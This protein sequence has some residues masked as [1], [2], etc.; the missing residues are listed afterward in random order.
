MCVESGSDIRHSYR[1]WARCMRR[2]LQNLKTK[3]FIFNILKESDVRYVERGRERE[4]ERESAGW[5][6]AKWKG[7]TRSAKSHFD[8]WWLLEWGRK[9]NRGYVRGHEEIFEEF[10]QNRA[11]DKLFGVSD[12][13]TNSKSPGI[14]SQNPCHNFLGISIDPRD[15]S[16]TRG[17]H[18]FEQT[19]AFR[20]SVEAYA[21]RRHHWWTLVGPANDE[22][23]RCNPSYILSRKRFDFWGSS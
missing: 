4:R 23:V 10:L 12:N 2:S 15:P 21:S 18:H 3:I 16:T 9:G 13:F 11:S 17:R 7:A 14:A 22:L 20:H 19:G 5:E 8:H 1:I 6:Y